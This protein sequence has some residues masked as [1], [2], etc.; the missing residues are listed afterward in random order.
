MIGSIGHHAI[1]GLVTTGLQGTVYRA[2][3]TR[4]GR[5]V[6]VH[7]LN[8]PADPLRR[9]HALDT[10][11]PFTAISHPHVA[12]LF[13]VGEHEG[14]VYLVYEF[15]P[16]DTLE[17]LIAGRPMNVRRAVDLATQVA[18][19]LAD[20]HSLDIIHGGLNLSTVAVT[21]K[22]HAKLLDVGLPAWIREDGR[23]VTA[24]RL[25]A[26][27]V[28]VTPEDVGFLAPEQLLG[29]RF[30]H[31]ADLFALGALL[32]QMLTGEA[33]WTASTSAECAVRVL[34]ANPPM[35]SA[36]NPEVPS[37]LDLV[38]TRALAKKPDDRYQSAAT[39]AADL[40][41]VA[42]ALHAGDAPIEAETAR[43]AAAAPPSRW[44]TVVLAGLL[45]AA[46]AVAAWQYA[47]PAKQVWRG[48][49]GT[50]IA[51]VIVV[52]PFETASA[53]P[54]RPY[55]GA[56][57]AEDLARRMGHVPGLAVPGRMSMRGLAGKGAQVA[58]QQIGA[59]AALWGRVAPADDEWKSLKVDVSLIDRTGRS[60]IWNRTYTV[61]AQDVIALQARI[62][63]E[64]AT[65]LRIVYAPTAEQQR[66]GLRLVDPAAYD[67]YL[68]GR[69]ALAA[70]DVSRAAQFFG[71]AATADPSLIEAQ[72]GLVE[73]LSLGVAF[74]GRFGLPEVHA[75]I[76]DAAEAA[77]TTDPDFAPTQ[78]AMGLASPTVSSALEHL[79]KAVTIDPSY[80]QAYLAM[81]ELVREA[82]PTRS[83]R[84]VRKALQQDPM[85]PFLH[86]ALAESN[87][88]TGET[89]EVLV[90]AARGQAMAPALPWWDALRTR[91]WLARR[92]GRDVAGP[93]AVRGVLAFPPYAIL[94]GASL[95][96][97]RHAADAAEL[98]TNLTRLYP[99]SC[100]ARAMAA[101][102][103]AASG[104]R[105]DAARSMN[106]LLASAE[107][108]SNQMLWA[109]CATMAAAA[110]SDAP[111]AATWMARAASSDDGVR[112]WSA[113]NGVLGAQAGLRQKIL[114][115]SN[116]ADSRDMAVA[117]QRM[118]AGLARVRGEAARLLESY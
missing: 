78:L 88:V 25:A 55:F 15:V 62:T 18:D 108:A 39:M 101:A 68:Q 31:R 104:G 24:D 5:T 94:R 83:I 71:S 75:R 60:P 38:V 87:L 1:L 3:D 30:D 109:R 90:E 33:A 54:A 72:T 10:V 47:E 97:D 49:F 69:E 76:V 99:G 115:W 74:D 56:G 45:V 53:D 77:S 92:T 9:A 34:Q 28:T 61:P 6:A 2:R 50:Q 52:L 89:S 73:A 91:V 12:T 42:S 98:L 107:L 65:W 100:E 106:E 20:A 105:E 19:A 8:G 82:D 44:R 37:G 86:Y 80:T 16:G 70:Y 11:R 57:F 7:V 40:R 66:A 118:E 23:D 103:R 26:G 58:A 85:Q 32:H 51:P 14:S 27:A 35:P 96:A 21:T 59:S 48:R 43:R 112:W 46:S 113:V 114:P 41:T 84:I 79:R 17:T 13:E 110:V 64:V 36:L 81:A 29:G 111:R 116:I 22:G 63:R 4:V 67:L 117:I 93:D 95:V 102:V